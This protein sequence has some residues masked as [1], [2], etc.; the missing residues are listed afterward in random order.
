VAEHFHGITVLTGQVG[1][2][3][4]D[5]SFGVV[6]ERVIDLVTYCKF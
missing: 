6:A 5:C 4:D 1:K 2:Y 3:S